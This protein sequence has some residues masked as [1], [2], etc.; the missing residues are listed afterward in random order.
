MSEAAI[1]AQLRS[2]DAPGDGGVA[3][4]TARV[5]RGDPQAMSD[6]YE[7][8]FDKSYRLARSLTRRDESFCLDV[9]QDAMLRVARSMKPIATAPEL[10]QWMKRVV[11]SAAIDL[12]RRE[13]RRAAREQRR[14]APESSETDDRVRWLQEQLDLL[15]PEERTMLTLRF[16]HERTLEQTGRALGLTGDALHGRLRRVLD[17]LRRAAPR[18]NDHD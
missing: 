14:D 12:L 5:A 2:G 13:A 6:F 1:E 18:E 7:A 9:V 4:L 11:H 8:W 17:R 15:E 16:L 10:E 3:D